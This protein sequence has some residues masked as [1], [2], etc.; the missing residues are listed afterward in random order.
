MAL[1]AAAMSVVFA[2]GVLAQDATAVLVGTVVDSTSGLPIQDVDVYLDRKLLADRSDSAGDFAVGGVPTGNH[3]LELLKPGYTVGGFRFSLTD[4]VTGQIDIGPLLLSRGPPPELAVSGTVH[5]AVT[6]LAVGGTT[7]TINRATKTYTDGDGSFGMGNAV[8]QWGPNSVEF[9]RLGYE[10]L[11][12]ELWVVNQDRGLQ[13]DAVLTP[14]AIR[15][16]EVVVEGERTT[17]AFGPIR[18]FYRRRRI[19]IGD[20]F[21]RAD[22]ERIRPTSV[23]SLLRRVPGLRIVESSLGGPQ[24]RMWARGFFQ[25]QPLLYRDGVRV[26]QLYLDMLWPEDIAGIEVYSRPSEIPIQYNPTGAACGALL[27]W[28]RWN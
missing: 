9:Q 19:G 24:V 7:V 1:V 28:T 8:L 2:P 25:C 12:S 17:V 5:D 16:S 4:G 20:F 10:P 11:F 13:L 22:I 27:I 18:Q 21:S 6:G 15:L 23:P 3:W 26:S 14:L